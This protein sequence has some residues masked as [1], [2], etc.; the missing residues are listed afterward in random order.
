MELPG[1]NT[2]GD[3]KVTITGRGSEH[4]MGILNMST[5]ATFETGR[6]AQQKYEYVHV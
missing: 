2:I 5:A 4:R 6:S 1:K 3:Y